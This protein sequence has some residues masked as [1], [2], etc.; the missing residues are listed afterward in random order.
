M[1]PMLRRA[2]LFAMLAFTGS[3]LAAHHSYTNFYIDKT[4][5][6][7]GEMLELQYVNPHVVLTIR[8][9]EGIYTAVWD[10]PTTIARR[11]PFTATTLRVG[12]RVVVV[13]NPSR[14]PGTRVLARLREVVRPSDGWRWYS[15]R[16]P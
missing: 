5:S 14:S 11:G 12:D 3:A 4:V 1:R 10:S 9:V 16:L 2:V 7:Q 8:T 15:P 6:I 13:G